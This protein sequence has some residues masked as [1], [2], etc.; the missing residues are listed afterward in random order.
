MTPLTRH[1]ISDLRNDAQR[2]RNESVIL[3]MLGG[4]KR[5]ASRVIDS[6]KPREVPVVPACQEL[7][8][9]ITNFK[10]AKYLERA[11]DSV[12]R[13]CRRV[14]VSAMEPDAEVEEVLYRASLHP[15][16]SFKV[17]R[18]V[19]LGLNESWLIAAYLAET[20]YVL[21]LHDD[22]A[23]KLE[24]A[25]AWTDKILPALNSGY[26]VTWRAE[27]L[28]DDGRATATEYFHGPTRRMSQRELISYLSQSQLSL[29]PAVTVFRRSTLINAVKEAGEYLTQPECHHTDG[30]LLGTE[31]LAHLRNAQRARG[32][33]Y[34]DKVLSQYGSHPGSG[35]I[36]AEQSKDLAP[37]IK[38]Y[39]VARAHFHAAPITPR[40]KPRLIFVYSDYEPKDAD[41]HVALSLRSRRA[42]AV[43]CS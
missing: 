7:T 8:V 30:V 22:D 6:L 37:L 40:V 27:H 21:V 36:Q 39:D 32:W 28:H 17:A 26:A 43:S 42:D 25:E 38:G 15:W 14:T 24:F 18:N 12:A 33:L 1:Q 5:A 3:K 35:T 31:V 29:S 13:V 10:R 16:K 23:L 2:K 20:E 11:L 19:D 34:I 9:C 41:A 4:D